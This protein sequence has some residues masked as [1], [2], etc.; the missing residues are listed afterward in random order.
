MN[1]DCSRTYYFF[2]CCVP[3]T[4]Q[5]FQLFFNK[6]YRRWEKFIQS[7]WLAWVSILTSNLK[8]KTVNTNVTFF[9]YIC[10]VILLI[11]SRSAILFLL[12]LFFHSFASPFLSAE[13]IFYFNSGESSASHTIFFRNVW[14]IMSSLVKV[15]LTNKTK[16]KV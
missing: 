12:L 9:I 15:H 16:I 11:Y 7:S 8:F 3:H 6:I 4:Q 10:L 13:F 14:N 5:E 1:I 2:I